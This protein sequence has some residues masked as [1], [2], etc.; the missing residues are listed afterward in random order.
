[1]AL[2]HHR[3]G[4]RSGTV[5]NT[6]STEFTPEIGAPIACLW[7][8]RLLSRG[9]AQ[10]MRKIS[11]HT[12]L[13]QHLG[14]PVQAAP[15]EDPDAEA[16]N[17]PLAPDLTPSLIRRLL[18]SAEADAASH[19]LPEP[20][21]SNISALTKELGLDHTAAQV[22]AFCVLLAND[23]QLEE[24]FC[25]VGDL[26][27]NRALSILE[28]LL[29]VP[30]L[31]LRST[32][33]HQS[34]L[35]R[36]GL[37]R[38]DHNNHFMNSKFDL[39]T[40]EFAARMVHHPMAPIEVLRGLIHLAP[41]GLLQSTDYAHITADL[42]VLEPYLQH[43]LDVQRSGVNAFIYGPPG[44]GK[45]QLTR[46][47]GV[48]MPCPVYEV[49]CEDTD[50]DPIDGERRL[51][52]W[53]VAQIFLKGQRALLVFDEAE[54]VFNNGGGLFSGPST[55]IQR[56]GWMNQRLESSPVPTVWLSN[57]GSPDAAFTRR[58][59]MVFELAS[60]PRA[61][62][63]AL[64]ADAA[65]ALLG[66]P[67][68]ERLAGI[69]V[70]APAVVER[71]ARVVHTV[72]STLTPAQHEPALLRLID[73]TLSAQG[74]GTLR[75]LH[76]HRPSEHYDPALINTDQDP[77]R[78]L[79]GLAR[80]GSARLC[81][82][83]APG[84]G[85]TAFAQWLAEQLERPLLVKRASDLLSKWVGQ[86][87]KNI[88]EAFDSAQRDNAVLL[89][90]EVDSFLRDRRGA[91]ASWEVTQVNE[92]LT[93][94]EQFEGL[95]IA[96]TNLMDGFDPA[97]LRRFDLKLRFDPLRPEQ[98]LTL[99]QSHCTAQSWA[100]PDSALATL[101]QLPQL[102]PGDFVAAMRQHRFAPLADTQ[103]L[104]KLLQAECALKEDTGRRIGFV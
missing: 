83:G 81:L 19:T 28:H 16:D 45:T 49:A 76:N 97:A 42:Q 50:G 10:M 11:D 102:T 67:A 23:S 57:S 62:R 101:S 6:L 66:A 86:A 88:A 65:G 84:T 9:G 52:A 2:A 48:Q 94:M 61:Q 70:L 37:L 35:H 32:V 30:V 56:K 41:A 46:L 54:D 51:R 53:Q 27:D 24:C 3:R 18:H 87:E 72:A 71:A 31:Q 40:T 104:L 90:D 43:A 64:L 33:A 69:E 36:S 96:S 77:Q 92:M 98:A 38:M 1:M 5:T 99:L 103:A 22:L 95:F 85:K 73:Q 8:L 7:I 26:S 47:L 20:L 59:D 100:L 13:V 12:A 93:Q 89:I 39:L 74:H 25:A 68:L 75:Q 44:I 60:P 82:Y 4:R 58:F 14:V 80:A 29:G 17:E 78:L 55:A 15:D 21:A 91:K 34:P 79:Q 63:R